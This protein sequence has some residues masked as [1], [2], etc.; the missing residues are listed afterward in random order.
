LFFVGTFFVLPYEN[1]TKA[2]LYLVLRQNAL[3]K[4]YCSPEE[5]LM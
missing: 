3:E 2:E 1:A 4:G 5:L